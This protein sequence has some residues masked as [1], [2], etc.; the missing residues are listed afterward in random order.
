MK[1]HHLAAPDAVEFQQEVMEIRSNIDA[2][3]PLRHQVKN[4][5]ERLVQ[6]R[7]GYQFSWLGVPVIRLPEDLLRQQEIMTRLRP[8]LVVEI[9]IARGG[10]LV[11]SASIQ[12]QLGILPNVIGIDHLIHDHAHQSIKESRYFDRITM[13]EAPSGSK[14]SISLIESRVANLEKVLLILDSDHTAEHVSMELHSYSRLLPSGS[15][16]MVCDTL[17]DE[18]PPGIYGDRDWSDSRGPRLGIERFLEKNSWVEEDIQLSAGLLITEMRG[19]FLRVGR[20]D[21]G[22]PK[23]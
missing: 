23:V 22:T 11:F 18:M 10:G 1:E 20:L 3:M 8:E 6:A 19:G 13:L 14:E 2:N 15:V 5:R 12:E 16:I 7:F 4:V 17:I 21:S 9:G